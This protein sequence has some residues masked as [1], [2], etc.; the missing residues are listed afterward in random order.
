MD[1][2]DATI[3][4]LRS[5]IPAASERGAPV[6]LTRIR[7]VLA[8]LGDPQETMQFVHVG[9]TSGKGST[10]TFMASILRAAGY[11]TGLHVSPHLTREHER[12]QV[13]GCA[14]SDRELDE[15]T[16]TV[17]SAVADTGA[18]LSYFE[19]LWA[20]ALLRFQR[21]ATQINVVEVGLGGELDATNVIDS[22][23]QIL[24]N[25]DLDHVA[26]LGRTK[27]AILRVKQG[28]LKPRSH[29]VS[30][31]REPHLRAILDE[32]AHACGSRVAF[33][34]RDFHSLQ[35]RQRISADGL[36]AGV[37]FRY[38]ERGVDFEDL[39]LGLAG[40]GQ[41]VNA[42]LAV[43]MALRMA[44]EWPRIDERS[45]REGLLAARPP[46]R[47][48][49]VGLDPLTVFDAAH[50]PAK[51]RWLASAV[52][53]AFPQRRFTTVFRYAPRADIWTTISIVSSFSD[54]I[55][56]T[57]SEHPG[58]MG[59]TPGYD[60]AAASRARKEHG[61][62]A[63]R[64]PHAALREAVNRVAGRPDDGVLVT[65]SVYMLQELYAVSSRRATSG[66]VDDLPSPSPPVGD[67]TS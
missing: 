46:G 21:A 17:R 29:V 26:V 61:A 20:I 11:G 9:G 59:L 47:V 67:G 8:A 52:R 58:D 62:I 57:D 28:I 35:R 53:S 23:Q 40:L 42:E 1:E 48:D 41:T 4:H 65:G 16:A 44:R 56:L 37:T 2:P 12:L 14:I 10:A 64:S 19:A 43:G 22:R 49:I 27:T 36:P 7:A 38:R 31:I 15:H 5:L 51:M 54:Q 32:H 45:I 34:G 63:I 66:D 33:A 13:D 30:G 25:I 18:A 39:A 6:D 50:N 60:K 24:T 3:A 55:I